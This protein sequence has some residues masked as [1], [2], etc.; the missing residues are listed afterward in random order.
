VCFQQQRTEVRDSEVQMT[1]ETRCSSHKTQKPTLLQEFKQHVLLLSCSEAAHTRALSGWLGYSADVTAAAAFSRS[2]L[3]SSIWFPCT[4]ASATASTSA[5][6]SA[7]SQTFIFKIAFDRTCSS[8]QMAL[9]L[10]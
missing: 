2:C 5:S 3:H 10:G 6:S 7:E 9:C 4:C 1:V 8:M